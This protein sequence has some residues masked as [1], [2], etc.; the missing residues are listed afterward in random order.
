MLAKLR[1]FCFL[2]L[3]LKFIY[4]LIYLFSRKGCSLGHSVTIRDVS[5][6]LCILTYPEPV[7][8]LGNMGVFQ[9]ENEGII[10]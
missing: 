6:D 7:Q 9:G 3:S 2:F 5:H 1:P 10:M 4:L 8:K